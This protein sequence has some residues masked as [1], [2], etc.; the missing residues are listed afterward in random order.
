[1]DNQRLSAIT[2]NIDPLAIV[3]I[4]FYSLAKDLFGFHLS[5]E[6]LLW[7]AASAAV[8]RISVVRAFERWQ[9]QQREAEYRKLVAEQ[10]SALQKSLA[11]CIA[12]QQTAGI[13]ETSNHN[14]DCENS[15]VGE[16]PSS[17]CEDSTSG[18]AA[19]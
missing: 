8:I 15:Q 2:R 4:F 16:S 11:T 1:M 7:F 17:A 19:G 14:A 9:Q 13:S 5:E 10:R 6:T 3:G 18:R 12:L